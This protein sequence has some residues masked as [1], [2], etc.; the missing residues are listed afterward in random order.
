MCSKSELL[1]P[2]T[3]DDDIPAA[4]GRQNPEGKEGKVAPFIPQHIPHH[5]DGDGGERRCEGNG[6]SPDGLRCFNVWECGIARG[7]YFCL[8][9]SFPVFRVLPDAGQRDDV[10][11]NSATEKGKVKCGKEEKDVPGLAGEVTNGPQGVVTH[12]AAGVILQGDLTAEDH[13]RHSQEE[14]P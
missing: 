2:H 12:P 8:C 7:L 13:R 9:Q 4:V 11:Y 1:I 3:V 10:D 14:A 5:K 6:Q